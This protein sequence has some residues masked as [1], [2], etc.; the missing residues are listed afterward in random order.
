M[1]FDTHVHLNSDRYENVEKIINDALDNVADSMT[2]VQMEADILWG[3]NHI[4]NL[5]EQNELIEKQIELL[6]RQYEEAKQY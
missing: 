4:N 1:Y 2:R 5:K 6:D 3:K